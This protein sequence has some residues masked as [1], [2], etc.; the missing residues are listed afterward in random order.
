[1]TDWSDWHRRYDTEPGMRRRLAIVRGWIAVTLDAA[2][3]GRIRVLSLC[4]GDGRD[5]LGVL[6]AHPRAA[7]ISARLIELDP[8][9]ADAARRTASIAGFPGIEVVEGDAGETSILA[10]AV[11][12]DLVLLCGVLGDVSD[13]DVARTVRTLPELCHTGGTVIWTRHRREPDLTPAIRSWLAEAG[14]EENA[15]EA[16]PESTASVGVARFRGP[17]APL[18]PGR[19]LFTF[20]D[21]LR[22]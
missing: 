15:F 10:G 18:V 14:F 1:V 22:G 5:L 17:S 11:P 9:L 6:D 8:V 21:S 7:D 12:A 16:V 2:R 13:A 19:R 20:D 3:A 4:S